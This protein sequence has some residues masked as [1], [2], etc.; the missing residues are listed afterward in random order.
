MGRRAGARYSVVTMGT[1]RRV[2]K[3]YLSIAAL[4]NGVVDSTRA[5][6]FKIAGMSSYQLAS[7]AAVL[8]YVPSSR[9]SAAPISLC[10]IN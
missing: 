2:I 10:W 3:G 5:A 4:N 7:L 9:E 6:S 1:Y 8:W